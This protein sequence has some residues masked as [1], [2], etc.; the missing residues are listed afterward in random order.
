LLSDLGNKLEG[1]QDG[2]IV[3]SSDKNYTLNSKFGGFSVGSTGATAQA[4]ISNMYKGDSY[5]GNSLL[6]AINQLGAGAMLEG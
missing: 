6:G 3:Y 5:A 2:F 1:I 4:F